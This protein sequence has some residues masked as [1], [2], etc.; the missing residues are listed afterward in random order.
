MHPVPFSKENALTS[1]YEDDPVS[2]HTLGTFPGYPLIP[3]GL[4][5]N[6]YIARQLDF[7]H[8][9]E[10]AGWLWLAGWPYSIRPLHRQK[11]MQREVL[12]TDSPQLHLVWRRSVIFVKPL[13]LFVLDHA[14]FENRISNSD[15]GLPPKVYD[16]TLGFLLSYVKLIQCEADLKIAID[17]G[18]F[19]S[20][21]HIT[22]KMWSLFARE[23]RDNVLELGLEGRWRYGELQSLRINSV[24]RLRHLT[25]KR[26]LPWDKTYKTAL[27]DYFGWLLVVFVY[28]TV[29]LTSMQV[30][31][32]TSAQPVT[33]DFQR[34]SF[35]FSVFC[36]VACA[37]ALFGIGFASGAY[38]LWRL[39]ENYR[40]EMDSRRRREEYR[41]GSRP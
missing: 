11:T 21:C 3:P 6:G 36:L 28:L 38:F 24:Y 25:L 27:H 19:P 8:I 4:D 39:S 22:W 29:V 23:V 5:E 13:P 37:A 41:K 16:A 30:V 32:A 14:F 33:L 12:I 1:G 2:G 40:R 26:L 7:S 17:L 31:L 10:I 35:R 18:L 20:T 9:D 34:T 15:S